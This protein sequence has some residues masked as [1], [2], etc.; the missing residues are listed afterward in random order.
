MIHFILVLQRRKNINNY[1][2]IEYYAYLKFRYTDIK[3]II[4]LI[5][6]NFINPCII[7]PVTEYCLFHDIDPALLLQLQYPVFSFQWNL[8]ACVTSF[9]FIYTFV[10]L[11][12]FL[13]L[14]GRIVSY[15]YIYIKDFPLSE[16]SLI[17]NHVQERYS[18]K[19][20]I[21]GS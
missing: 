19:V 11:S 10:N 21:L 15:I 4:S 6:I 2:L 17:P 8:P 20:S 14:L 3:H 5:V 18:R 1:S 16:I 12:I 13:H 9:Y 7:S